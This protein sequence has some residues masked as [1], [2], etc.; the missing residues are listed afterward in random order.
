MHPEETDALKANSIGYAKKLKKDE[1][2]NSKGYLVREVIVQD[3]DNS[4]CN[5]SH[6]A[7]LVDTTRID[8]KWV[9]DSKKSIVGVKCCHWKL[10]ENQIAV[11]I[12]GSVFVG[13]T[14]Y[15]PELASILG[16]LL[17]SRIYLIEGQYFIADFGSY[18]KVYWNC[19][20]FG[21]LLLSVLVPSW[22]PIDSLLDKQLWTMVRCLPCIG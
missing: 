10:E 19:V 21:K 13:T 14:K 18:Q 3:A 6:Y 12:I 2:E 20:A 7:L 15:T 22:N 5:F 11:A 9:W 8:L 16:T 17:Q 1:V 4:G